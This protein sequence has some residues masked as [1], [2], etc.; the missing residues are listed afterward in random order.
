MFRIDHILYD[1]IAAGASLVTFTGSQGPAGIGVIPH[2]PMS[3]RPPNSTR[4]SWLDPLEGT[5]RWGRWIESD[6]RWLPLLWLIV[7]Y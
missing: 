4:P 2:Q 7:A 6:R 1:N 5:V 3:M